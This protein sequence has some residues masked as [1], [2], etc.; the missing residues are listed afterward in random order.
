VNRV[1]IAIVMTAIA[2]WLTWGNVAAQSSNE[3]TKDTLVEQTTYLC[4]VV[5][6]LDPLIVAQIQQISLNF[7]NG[8][9]ARLQRIGVLTAENVQASKDLLMQDRAAHLI[10]SQTKPCQEVEG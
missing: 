4:S 3:K 1:V 7:K 8:T 6:A 9:Y 10:L 2:G 5:R